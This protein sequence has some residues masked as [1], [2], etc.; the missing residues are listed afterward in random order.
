MKINTKLIHTEQNKQSL[1]QLL[2]IKRQYFAVFFIIMA[3]FSDHSGYASCFR[4]DFA[5]SKQIMV[6][7]N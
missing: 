3:H 5:L 6:F 7:C 2:F 1:L 4:A